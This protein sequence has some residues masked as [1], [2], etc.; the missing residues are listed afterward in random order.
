MISSRYFLLL[1]I[2]LLFGGL[3]SSAQTTP[4]DTKQFTKDGL[5]LN[6]PAGWSFNDTSNSDAQDLTLDVPT[7]MPRSRSLSF[8]LLSQLPRNWPKRNVFWLISTSR[9]RRNLL[10]IWGP[11]LNRHRRRSK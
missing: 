5:I 6:Y 10:R 8:V 7:L 1:I 2:F 11:S 4:G 9:Q 3:S